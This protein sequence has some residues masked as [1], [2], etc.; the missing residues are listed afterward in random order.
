MGI[1]R[2]VELFV[3]SMLVELFRSL[4]EYDLSHQSIERSCP[5]YLQESYDPQ[6]RR[7]GL[8]DRDTTIQAKQKPEWAW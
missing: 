8:R 1:L 2:R 4:N 6:R 3:R 7:L 5:T